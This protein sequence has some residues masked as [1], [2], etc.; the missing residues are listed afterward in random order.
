MGII[1]PKRIL[2]Q[3]FI[4]FDENIA[5]YHDQH[6]ERVGKWIKEGKI[7]TRE[8]ATDGIDNAI[9]G[10]LGMLAG[11][12]FGKAVLKVADID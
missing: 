1:V 4:R 10:F 5:K 11:K 3:G 8:D 12:N 6:Q 7:K 9:D 2:M